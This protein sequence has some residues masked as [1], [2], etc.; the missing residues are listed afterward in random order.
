MEALYKQASTNRPAQTGQHK[1]TDW[2][3]R[4][5]VFDDENVTALLSHTGSSQW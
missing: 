5:G 2:P 4:T 3:E 1:Q